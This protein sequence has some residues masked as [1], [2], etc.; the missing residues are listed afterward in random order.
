MNITVLGCGR[1]GSFLAWYHSR[2]NTVTLW[3]R[4]N[5][6]SF[7]SL[8]ATRTNEYVTLPP[9]IILT[10]DLDAALA[11][12]D[13]IVISISAQ[14]L[15]IFAKEINA[16]PL[17]GKTFVLCMKG[18]EAESG[19]R[20]STV[21]T[22]EVTQEIKVAVWVGPGHVQDFTQEIP[23]CMVVDSDDA[24]VV[25]FIVDTLSSDLIRLYKGHDIIGTEVG[26]AAKNVIGIAAGMLD[27]KHLSSL[28]GSLMA[29][30][31]REIS[32]LMKAMGANELSAYGLCHL[33]D[34]EATLFSPHSHNRKFG[35]AYINGEAY[36]A[37]AEGVATTKALVKLAEQ[38]HVDLPICKAIETILYE[39][40]D[41]DT[42]LKE[43]F[44]RSV[45]GEFDS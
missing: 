39:N 6:R 26:A 1:W 34:Y 22:E 5:S 25:D 3:G 36:T 16:F 7:A 14:Q 32:R 9:E 23:N 2:K 20:L 29:R 45:K 17:A 24:Q 35:E 13:V 38:Y 43:L 4:A 8:Y 18:L 15:R 19:K 27:G 37:L 12:S 21:F 11:A 41:G 33:G 40:K 44:R 30:G 42:V 31:A 10:S 28:K